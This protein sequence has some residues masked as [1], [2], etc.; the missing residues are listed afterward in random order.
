MKK[1]KNVKVR[2]MII[3]FLGQ[4]TK[5]LK[6]KVGVDKVALTQNKNWGSPFFGGDSDVICQLVLGKKI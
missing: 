2:W 1:E 5:W 4:N 3:I 6:S